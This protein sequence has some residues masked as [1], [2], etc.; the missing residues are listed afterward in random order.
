[1]YLLVNRDGSVNF[2]DDHPVNPHLC[3][4]RVVLVELPDKSLSEVVGDIAPEEALWNDEQQ[5]IVRH[6]YFVVGG[7][8]WRRRQASIKINQH[9]PLSKQLNILRGSDKAAKKA[10]VIFI[11]ACRDWSNDMSTKLNAIDSITP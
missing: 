9:Y 6:P 4:E 1:M 2:A 5:R 3:F 10:M 11:D 7:E 8:A